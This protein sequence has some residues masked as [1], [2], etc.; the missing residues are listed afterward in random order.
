VAASCISGQEKYMQGSLIIVLFYFISFHN[1]RG[2]K[3]KEKKRKEK[4]RNGVC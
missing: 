2:E 4:K 3:E 1:R